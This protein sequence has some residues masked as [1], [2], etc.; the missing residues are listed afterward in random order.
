M[1]VGRRKEIELIA[2]GVLAVEGSVLACRSKGASNTYLPGGH[3]EFGE[4]AAQALAREFFE[5]AGIRIRVGAFLGAVENL[6][7]Q[8]GERHCEVNLVFAVASDEVSPDAPVPSQESKISFS[9]QPAD[10]LDECRME[11]KVL[12]R[13]V[14]QWIAGGASVPRWASHID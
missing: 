6:F 2:R 10:R 11:P 7:D 8:D 12:H 3:V 4:T 9:W 1:A 13:L 14:P 5:E